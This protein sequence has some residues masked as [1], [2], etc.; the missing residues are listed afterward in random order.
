MQKAVTKNA[1]DK[2]KSEPNKMRTNI[3]GSWFRDS[4]PLSGSGLL[5]VGVDGSYPG[6]WYPWSISGSGLLSVGADGSYPGYRD[7]SSVSGTGGK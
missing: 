2:I 1:T 6:F 4:S 7:S 5:S 3:M